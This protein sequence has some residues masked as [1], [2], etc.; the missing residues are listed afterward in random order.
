MNID[1]VCV[2]TGFFHCYELSTFT[3]QSSIC[4]KSFDFHDLSRFLYRGYVFAGGAVKQLND[5]SVV[6][7]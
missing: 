3:E 2:H 4:K 5:A 7:K 1:N 6:G